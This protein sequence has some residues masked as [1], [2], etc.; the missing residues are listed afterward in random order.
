MKGSFAKIGFDVLAR[1][2]LVVT[3][4][5]TGG[6][7]LPLF[8]DPDAPMTFVPEAICVWTITFF[9]P[10]LVVERLRS[11]VT[12]FRMAAGSRGS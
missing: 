2:Y 1:F 4:V 10:F 3:A 7:Y 11:V 9:V 5:L 12:A 6:L 8:V